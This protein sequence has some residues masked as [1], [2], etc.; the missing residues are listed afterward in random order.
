MPDKWGLQRDFLDKMETRG[1]I[2][3]DSELF[4]ATTYLIVDGHIIVTTASNG[5]LAVEIKN[6]KPFCEELLA[7]ADEWGGRNAV[8]VSKNINKSRVKK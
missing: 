8:N 7:V 3:V 6:I 5:R 1:A 2:G 4:S